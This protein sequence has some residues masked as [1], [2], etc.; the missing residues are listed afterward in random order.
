MPRRIAGSPPSRR[1]CDES[2]HRQQRCNWCCISCR[3]ATTT[4]P[5]ASA[6]VVN[7][8]S[9]ANSIALCRQPCSSITTGT[10]DRPNSP[11]EGTRRNAAHRP[12][13]GSA[14]ATSDPVSARRRDICGAWLAPAG[15]WWTTRGI[16]THLR[17]RRQEYPSGTACAAT[18]QGAVSGTGLTRSVLSTGP[19]TRGRR[20]VRRAHV[21]GVSR[22]ARVADGQ[23]EDLVV[24]GT[25]AGGV[26]HAE[27]GV[28]EGVG[29]DRHA[30][31][32]RANQ[33]RALR[34]VG[35]ARKGLGAPALLR[36]HPSRSGELRQN[37]HRWTAP[38]RP[39]ESSVTSKEGRWTIVHRTLGYRARCG[40]S[41]TGSTDC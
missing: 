26:G 12:A 15:I 38:A 22:R 14:G 8:D 1:W 27:P 21:T 35:L 40:P 41:A 39:R 29:R 25:G 33:G 6:A 10:V 17:C 19:A 7:P 9:L 20:D 2:Y 3:G 24:D 4:N 28:G 23:A 37:G 18:A 5:V 36:Q 34:E 30:W 13:P 32:R 11:R 31:N 16:S